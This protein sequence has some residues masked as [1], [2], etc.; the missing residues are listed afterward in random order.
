VEWVNSYAA[1]V[2]DRAMRSGLANVRLLSADAEL[3]F[4]KALPDQSVWRVH[5]YFPDPW[6]KTKHHRR[7]LIKP[8]FAAQVRRV[9]KI[10]GWVGVVT[11]HEEYFGQVQRVFD[12]QAG[13]IQVSFP[14]PSPEGGYVGTNF[15]KKYKAGGRRFFALAAIRYR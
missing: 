7:R 4:K 14:T 15:E 9:L 11:D 12:H 10:G 13:L 2:A 1:Y 5:I 8:L 6:P 3:L